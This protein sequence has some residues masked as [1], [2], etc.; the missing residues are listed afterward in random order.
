MHV[1]IDTFEGFDEL[2]SLIALGVLNRDVAPVGEKDDFVR[3]TM[4]NVAPFLVE[5]AVAA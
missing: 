4:A 3:R 1:A 5:A 2:D